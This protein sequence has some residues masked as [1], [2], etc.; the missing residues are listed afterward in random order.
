MKPTKVP[1]QKEHGQEAKSNNP[2]TWTT[3]EAAFGAYTKLP[4]FWRGIGY[5]FAVGDPY[6]GIDLDMCLSPDHSFITDWAEQAL[7]WLPHAYA[8]FSPS[9]RGLKL[10]ARGK[11]PI[12]QK[13]EECIR[14][15]V[16]GCCF[17]W[18]LG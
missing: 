14:T 17:G 13:N 8:E 4:Y 2:S 10:I 7:R 9:D 18:R 5:M 16:Q 1:F 15:N 3:F 12:P 11:F 6:C